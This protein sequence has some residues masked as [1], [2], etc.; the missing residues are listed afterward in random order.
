MQGNDEFIV[1]AAMTGLINRVVWI[2]PDWAVPHK[3][4][5]ARFVFAGTTEKDGKTFSCSCTKP[6]RTKKSKGPKQNYTCSY[7]SDEDLPWKFCK[8]VTKAFK[9]FVLSASLF[10][11]FFNSRVFKDSTEVILLFLRKSSRPG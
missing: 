1:S 2:K 5:Y 7:Y 3:T 8:P 10:Q 9:F 6:L 11:K 4:A